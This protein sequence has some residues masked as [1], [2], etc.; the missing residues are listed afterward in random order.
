MP[1]AAESQSANAVLMV[2]P[3][4]FSSNPETLASNTFQ[5]AAAATEEMAAR[6]QVEFSRNLN[7][8]ASAEP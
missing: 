6:A 4:A 7:A 5:S 8:L 3:T 2:R 1:L